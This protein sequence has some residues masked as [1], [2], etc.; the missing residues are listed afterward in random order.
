KHLV[1]GMCETDYS[2]YPD[3]RDDTLK[4]LQATL[5]LG[6]ESRLVID[7]PLMGLDKAATW[8]LAEALGG[9]LLVDLIR[10]ET[11]SCYHGDREH[12]PEWGFGCGRCPACDLRKAGYEKFQL[13]T[14]A[15]A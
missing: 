15:A 11:H 7:T 5:N 4:A 12:S 3:C 10:E 8:H 2:G 6:L 1:G 14:R 9:A 13:A